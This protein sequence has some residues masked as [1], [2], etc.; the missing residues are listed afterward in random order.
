MEI[1]QTLRNHIINNN[2]TSFIPN[3]EIFTTILNNI[4][5]QLFTD[6][7]CQNNELHYDQ[8]IARCIDLE[9]INEI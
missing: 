8:Y 6:L 5:K 1:L 7:Q 3:V 2:K 9:G 4:E